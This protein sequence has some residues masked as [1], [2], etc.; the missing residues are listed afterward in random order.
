MTS[1]NLFFKVFFQ[2]FKKRIWS[3]AILFVIMFFAFP[4]SNMMVTQAEISYGKGSQMTMDTAG[5]LQEHYLESAFSFQ[6]SFFIILLVL[7]AVFLAVSG[8]SYLNS[9]KKVDFVHSMPIKREMLFAVKFL[10]GVVNYVLPLLVNVGMSLLV[11]VLNRPAAAKKLGMLGNVAEHTGWFLLLN[12]VFFLLFYSVAVLVMMLVGNTIIA[13]LGIGVLYFYHTAFSLLWL[14]LKTIF[15]DT[16]CTPYETFKS[17][18]PV[19]LLSGQLKA[20]GKR[21]QY[22]EWGLEK[23]DYGADMSY[24]YIALGIIAA[25]VTVSVLLIKARRSESAG[26]A[27]AFKYSEPVIKIAILAPGIVGGSLFMS[28][29]SVGG[30]LGWLLFGAVVSFLLLSVILEMIFRL[31]FRGALQ[32][33]WSAFA[34]GAAAILLLAFFVFDLGGFDTK[35]PELSQLRSIGVDFDKLGMEQYLLDYYSDS[36]GRDWYYM[37]EQV[38][39]EGES[40]EEAYTLAQ[41]LTEHHKSS[42]VIGKPQGIY[43]TDAKDSADEAEQDG[44]IHICYRLKNGKKIYRSYRISWNEELL[45]CASPVYRSE[46]YQSFIEGTHKKNANYSQMEYLIGITREICEFEEGQSG[47]FLDV[48]FEELKKLSLK[49]VI[50]DTPVMLFELLADENG[51]EQNISY[52][53]FPSFEKTLAYLE[54]LGIEQDDLQIREENIGQVTVTYYGDS[55]EEKEFTDEAERSEIIENCVSVELWNWNGNYGYTENYEVCLELLT[56]EE[57]EYY[58]LKEVPDFVKKA[59]Q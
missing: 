44:I 52:P 11:V 27:L 58:Y 5:F 38:W 12:I 49:E 37:A 2:E 43:V 6:N 28:M 15:Y 26:K 29:T 8:F 24:V 14:V 50:Y 48:Y 18:D 13:F 59:F 47:E 10:V 54:T 35:L 25:A 31:D 9:R 45:E 33:K 19:G 32:H 22:G 42:E 41:Y 4:V 17:Y 51:W 34:G 55:C 56:E 36:E 46:E 39:M 20:V 7:S 21:M 3:A 57:L 23:I 30:S 40:M 16:F 1:R 53:V